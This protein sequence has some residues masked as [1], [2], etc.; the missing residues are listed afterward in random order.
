MYYLTLHWACYLCCRYRMNVLHVLLRPLRCMGVG[1][2][3][4]LA[5]RADN[6]LLFDDELVLVLYMLVLV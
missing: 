4:L 6:Y 3:G 1:H 5:G 2:P